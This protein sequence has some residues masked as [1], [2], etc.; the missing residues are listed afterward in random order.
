MKKD[1]FNANLLLT[2][3]EKAARATRGHSGNLQGFVEVRIP[4][5]SGI[6]VVLA[7]N[8]NHYGARLETVIKELLQ[9]D[10]FAQEWDR[11]R[12][13]FMKLQPPDEALQNHINQKVQ[14]AK[15]GAVA[16]AWQSNS[17][18]EEKATFK[19]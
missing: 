17:S 19:T 10:Q 18:E 16:Q 4:Q 8:P 15:R 6:D 14:D 13:K 12:H 9:P 2:Q 5:P 3:I 1:I 7:L 11:R